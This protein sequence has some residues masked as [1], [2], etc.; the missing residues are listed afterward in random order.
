MVILSVMALEYFAS[1]NEIMVIKVM[2]E[3]RKRDPKNPKYLAGII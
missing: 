3:L 2:S 1:N